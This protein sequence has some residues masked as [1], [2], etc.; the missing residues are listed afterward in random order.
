MVTR[1]DRATEDPRN[2]VISHSLL[3]KCL[4][5]ACIWATNKAGDFRQRG[6]ATSAFG[7]GGTLHPLGKSSLGVWYPFMAM[8]TRDD[9]SVLLV[10]VATEEA[11]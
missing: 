8:T 3:L 9:R 11:W 4:P 2:S 10:A 6:G 1:T 7:N 5:G